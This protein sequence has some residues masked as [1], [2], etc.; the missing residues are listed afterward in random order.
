MFGGDDILCLMHNVW[1]IETPAISL[2][3]MVVDVIPLKEV[4]LGMANSFAQSSPTW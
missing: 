1:F 4:E 3:Y 2:V